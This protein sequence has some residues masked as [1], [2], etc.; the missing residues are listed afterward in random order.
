MN[1]QLYC[2]LNYNYYDHQTSCK[3]G[4]AIVKYVNSLELLCTII[5]TN[6]IDVVSCPS[7]SEKQFGERS[8]I[9]WAYSPKVVK[10]NEIVRS[11]IIVM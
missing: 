8:Q 11:L 7:P 10:T 4:V 9:S 1:F 6:Y 2:C 5:H 3:V